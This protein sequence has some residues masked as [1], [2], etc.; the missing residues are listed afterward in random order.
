VPALSAELAASFLDK[1]AILYLLA[2]KQLILIIARPIRKKA[3]KMMY[4]FIKAFCE[5]MND[6]AILQQKLDKVVDLQ[7]VEHAFDI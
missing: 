3:S 1:S 7:D 5:M 4:W 2:K 6:Y